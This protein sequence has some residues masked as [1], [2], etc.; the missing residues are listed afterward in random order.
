M[1]AAANDLNNGLLSWLLG[2]GFSFFL[3]VKFPRL[4]ITAAC[5]FGGFWILIFLINVSA[6]LKY[7]SITLHHAGR[8][9]PNSDQAG[10]TPRWRLLEAR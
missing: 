1:H 2:L 6:H 10:R 5:L 4:M 9:G 3:W 8:V 7:M